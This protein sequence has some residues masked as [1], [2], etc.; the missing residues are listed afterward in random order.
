MPTEIAARDAATPW[1]AFGAMGE[2]LGR[3]Y[4]LIDT[5]EVHRT[6][7]EDLSQLEKAVHRLIAAG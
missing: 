4:H 1:G 2:V 7:D 3:N 5:A 6:V